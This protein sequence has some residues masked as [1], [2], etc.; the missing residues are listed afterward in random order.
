MN[1]RQDGLTQGIVSDFTTDNEKHNTP[2]CWYRYYE[3]HYSGGCDEWGDVIPGTGRI[4]VELME[5]PVIKKTP[6]GAWVGWDEH[7]KKFVNLNWNKRYALPTL[8]E[9]KASYRARKRREISLME[10]RANGARLA[11][12]AAEKQ[13]AAKPE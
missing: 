12:A 3:V 13:W 11:L 1:T 6:C 7:D 2:E 9:A 4:A 8:E 5:I 10:A